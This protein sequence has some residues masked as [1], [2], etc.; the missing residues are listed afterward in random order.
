MNNADLLRHLDKSSLRLDLDFLV[1]VCV[2][3]N[4][5]LMPNG[6]RASEVKKAMKKLGWLHPIGSYFAK[7]M[8]AIDSIRMPC[9]VA[10]CVHSFHYTR[11]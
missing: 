10:S 4:A 7:S 1:C 5:A 6:T 11:I 8:P 3:V 2:C 9:V